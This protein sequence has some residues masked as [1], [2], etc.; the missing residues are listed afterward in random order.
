MAEK[1]TPNKMTGQKEIFFRALSDPKF[2]EAL[3][4]NP[5]KAMQVGRLSPEMRREV[6]AIL[7]S[8]NS[9]QSHISVLADNLLCF[10]GGP[11]GSV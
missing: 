7:T 8:V 11:F 6:N 10:G 9:I 1:R 3:A 4:I 2:R 5:E